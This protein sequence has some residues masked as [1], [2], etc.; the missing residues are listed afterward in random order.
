MV[1]EAQDLGP[2]IVRAESLVLLKDT[3]VELVSRNRAVDRLVERPQD[4][5]PIQV[6]EPAAAKS[7][8]SSRIES[9]PGEDEMVTRQAMTIDR[10][11]PSAY[12][13][14]QQQEPQGR[15]LTPPPPPLDHFRKR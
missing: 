8:N 15:N 12:P 6:V 2:R 1:G 11:V 14:A 9:N 10:F 3:S 7:I 4:L 5:A 13:T